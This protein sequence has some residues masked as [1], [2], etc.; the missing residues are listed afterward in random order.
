M[1]KVRGKSGASL[2]LTMMLVLA[3]LVAM[4][5]AGCGGGEDEGG[6]TMGE[7]ATSAVGSRSTTDVPHNVTVTAFVCPFDTTDVSVPPD[8]GMVLA[9]VGLKIINEGDVSYEANANMFVI[10]DSAGE[11]YIHYQFYTADDAMGSFNDSN[12]VA[13]GEELEVS[14]LFEVPPEIQL[15]GVKEGLGYPNTGDLYPLP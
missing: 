6:T 11:D 4:G 3:S 5:F 8:E 9:K 2:L 13:P 1:I 12:V 14:L 15:V 10:E 7:T